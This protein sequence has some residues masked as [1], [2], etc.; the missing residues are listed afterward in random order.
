MKNDVMKRNNC[1]GLLLTGGNTSTVNTRD[2]KIS[3]EQFALHF[4]DL[5]EGGNVLS[6]RDT[7]NIDVNVDVNV[8]PQLN[9]LFTENEVVKGINV[10]KNN[11]ACGYDGIIN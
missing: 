8:N 6:P 10:L 3:C 2:N 5:N 11:K 4:K 1:T 9:A 7:V